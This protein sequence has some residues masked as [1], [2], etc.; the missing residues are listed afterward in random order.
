MCHDKMREE[1]KTQEPAW[2]HFRPDGGGSKRNIKSVAVM[3]HLHLWPPPS[4][5]SKPPHSQHRESPSRLWGHQERK[6]L[7]SE[8]PSSS[9]KSEHQGPTSHPPSEGAQLLARLPGVQRPRSGDQHK[10]LKKK[11][12]EQQ[13]EEHNYHSMGE[14]RKQRVG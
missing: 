9:G 7:C 5:P 14:A 2:E 6:T 12:E 11:K 8:L 13:E 1:A 10:N 4:S 3:R